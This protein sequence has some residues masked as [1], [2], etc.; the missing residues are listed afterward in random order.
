MK[1]WSINSFLKMNEIPHIVC[2]GEV[3]WDIF[4]DTKRL[5]G[6]PLNLA[7]R[8]QSLGAKSE[9]VSAIGNDQ[10]G[11]E[12]LA[13]LEHQKFPT[14]LIQ[15][16]DFS[17]GRV[18]VVLDLK[19]S[20]TYTIEKNVA[21]DHI[22][23]TP[24][25]IETIKKSDAF[26]FGSLVCRSNSNL[27]IVKYLI[28]ISQYSF[29]DLN[30]RAPFYNKDLILD[31]IDRADFIKMNDEEVV[32]VCNWMDINY[33]N[34]TGAVEKLAQQLQ[35]DICVTLGERGALLN[36]NS[37]HYFH[38]SY[39]TKVIDTV[40]AGDSFFAGLIFG[41]LSNQEPEKAL[42][43]GCAL[44][45]IVAGKPGA[46]AQVTKHEINSVILGLGRNDSRR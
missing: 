37:M 32:L 31:L 3:L 16:V 38:P 24:I 11:G 10:E 28:D 19:G 8:L 12:T 45:S 21:W 29:F 2:Y 14:R 36:Y 7:I 40:G 27:E 44:G 22:Q 9:L 1:N 33:E 4:I 42:Q 35:K 30:L 43:L 13:F 23:A 15:K 46:T 34:I 20:P 6:A 5:G 39:P 17:T 18:Q 41:L 25:A 26:V